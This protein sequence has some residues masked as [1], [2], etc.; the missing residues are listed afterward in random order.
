[1]ST[2]ERIPV[3]WPLYDAIHEFSMFPST[4]M[5][6]VPSP[7]LFILIEL[8]L[9]LGLT[10]YLKTCNLKRTLFRICHMLSEIE[11]HILNMAKVHGGRQKRLVGN[12]L[13][14]MLVLCSDIIYHYMPHH[15]MSE[16]ESFLC[17]VPVKVVSSFP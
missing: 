10:M 1:M 15:P 5:V 14:W 13:N 3:L 16:K 17:W 7:F 6:L 4:Y 12:S 9:V 11:K 8:K 2:Q